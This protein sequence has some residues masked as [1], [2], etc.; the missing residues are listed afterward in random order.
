MPF[1][2]PLTGPLSTLSLDV[3]LPD[4]EANGDLGPPSYTHTRPEP[5][6]ARERTEHVYHLTNGK[7]KP[8]ANLKFQSAA[9]CPEHVPIIF[10]GEA[11]TG[12]FDLDVN[13]DHILD[14]V[15]VVTKLLTLHVD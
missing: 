2:L 6:T 12:T 8:T 9:R 5:T 11:I 15:I 14:I 3:D 13:K 4:Y 10:E 1:A 7:N